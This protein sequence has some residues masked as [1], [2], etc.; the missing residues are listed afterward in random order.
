MLQKEP[1]KNRHLSI[2]IVALL[3]LISLCYALYQTYGPFVAGAVVVI[4]QEEIPEYFDYGTLSDSIYCNDFFEFSVPILKGHEA[5]YKQYDYIEK[6][7]YERDSVW[8]TPKRPSVIRD[9]DLLIVIPELVKLDY[10]KSFMET[11][12][13]E[14]FQKYSKEKTKREMFG[15]DYQLIIRAHNLEGSTSN[16]YATRF[17]NLHNPDYGAAKFKEISGISFREYQG[18]ESHGG[19]VQQIMFQTMGGENR[20]IISYITQIH[21]FS[22]SIDL[23]YLTEEQKC[24][25]LEMVDSIQ[26]N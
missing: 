26:F 8:A 25:L 12:S 18:L 10:V 3:F 11:R 5:T 21:G 15:A 17:E 7:I 14:G 6:S 20:K 16:A 13:I 9:Q 2:T 22:L 4:E 24:I 19:S 23:F 1:R